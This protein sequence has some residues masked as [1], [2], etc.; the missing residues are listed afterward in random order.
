VWSKSFGS[1]SSLTIGLP[2]L[3]DGIFSYQKSE[4]GDIGKGLEMENV[5]MFYGYL[6]YFTDMG[7]FCVDLVYF[8]RFGMLYR[9]KS[10]NPVLTAHF[11][12]LRIFSGSK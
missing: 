12:R 5:G 11:H 4:F 6:E 9:E 10:G 2:G 7:I 8:P 1:Q 3:P